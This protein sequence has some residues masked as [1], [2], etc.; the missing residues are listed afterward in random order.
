MR[1]AK[2]APQNRITAMA[3]MIISGCEAARVRTFSIRLSLRVMPAAWWHRG[4]PAC[5]NEF[6]AGTVVAPECCG[7]VHWGVKEPLQREP[8]FVCDSARAEAVLRGG[9]YR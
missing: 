7:N 4:A 5:R 6:T 9:F 1:A 2:P 3:A 8:G